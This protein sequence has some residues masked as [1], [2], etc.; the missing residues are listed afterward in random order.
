MTVARW[1]LCWTF[2]LGSVTCFV[3]AFAADRES[4]S[5]SGEMS[6]NVTDPEIM[7]TS[8]LCYHPHELLVIGMAG[9]AAMVGA[10]VFKPEGRG[11]GITESGPA[12]AQPW[13]Q[14]PP[15]Q[16]GHYR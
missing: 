6:P 12:Q 11:R 15:G 7:E 10:L 16:G 8:Q 2:F 1:V 9:V 14:H 4:A 5:C 13:M 3:W